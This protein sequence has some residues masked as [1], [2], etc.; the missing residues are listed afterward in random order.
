MKPPQCVYSESSLRQTLL[1]PTELS[2]IERVSSG[3]GLIILSSFK[4]TFLWL[5]NPLSLPLPL[6]PTL[7]LSLSLSHPYPLSLPHSLSL[8]RSSLFRWMRC[9]LLVNSRC[10]H[11]NRSFLTK[12]TVSHQLRPLYLARPLLQKHATGYR[13]LLRTPDSYLV[14]QLKVAAQ[15]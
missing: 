2:V 10:F 7:S 5:L 4:L 3:Q 9:T 13:R 11:V 8:P 1:G 6:S 12:L 15:G 14:V